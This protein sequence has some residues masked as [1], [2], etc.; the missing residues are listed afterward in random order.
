[1]SIREVGPTATQRSEGN[2][3]VQLRAI[4]RG[5]TS[6]VGATPEF[7]EI[8]LAGFVIE[9]DF[10]TRP[11]QMSVA[12]DRAQGDLG[13]SDVLVCGHWTR[14]G[15]DKSR[16]SSK[17][18]IEAGIAGAWHRTCE[19]VE[20]EPRHRHDRCCDWPIDVVGELS[21]GAREL[22]LEGGEGKRGASVLR[23]LLHEYAVNVVGKRSRIVT[24]RRESLDLRSECLYIARRR[25]IGCKVPN[26]CPVYLRKFVVLW[27]GDT[28]RVRRANIG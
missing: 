21:E 25:T 6:I 10:V 8:V 9:E 23:C 7:S 20:V 4:L 13:D 11:D 27:D 14:L 16:E 12:V 26:K 19:I 15:C 22:A 2:Q 28:D 18:A 24:G 3:R 1:M 5:K 17:T